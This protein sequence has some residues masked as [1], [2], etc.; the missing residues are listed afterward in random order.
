MNNKKKII[1]VLPARGGSKRIKNKNI[2]NFCGK[3]IIYYVLDTLKK[4]NIFDKIFVSTDSEKIKRIVEKKGFKVDFLRSK[5]LSNDKIGILYVLKDTLKK[6]ELK[7]ICFDHAA[8]VFPCS[9]LLRKEDLK[10][11][12]KIFKKNNYKY[13]VLSIA[14]YVSPPNRSLS[15]SRKN[16]IKIDD[17]KKF[18][19]ELSM[20]KKFFDTGNF[21]FFPTKQIDKIIK[22]SEKNKPFYK[23]IP[24][25]LER[26]IAVDINTYED[27]EYAK[28]LYFLINKIK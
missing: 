9:P 10:N 22:N 17:I 18:R 1:A 21:S 19:N 27:L 23:Y 25:I 7:N 6:F 28:K 13:P 14:E 5:N 8:I 4:S 26:I 16:F 24:Y 15:L 2:I 3:P 20:T 12:Y 11:G